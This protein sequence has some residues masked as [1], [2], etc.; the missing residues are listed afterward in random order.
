MTNPMMNWVG[1]QRSVGVPL[2]SAGQ[3]KGRN[4]VGVTCSPTAIAR[5]SSI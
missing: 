5:V 1:L 3:W 4:P 2:D